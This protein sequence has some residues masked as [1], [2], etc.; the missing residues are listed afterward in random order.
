MGIMDFVI[1]GGL[2]AFG[3]IGIW[4]GGARLFFGF[5]MLLII[6]VGSAF[7]SAAVTPHIL[8]KDTDAGVE[9]TAPAQVIMTPLGNAFPSDGD[10]AIL[11]DTE[12]TLGEDEELYIGDSGYKL[13]DVLS[14]NIP[15]VGQFIASFVIKAAIPG[16]SLRESVTY[17]LTSYIYEIVIWVILVIILAIIR[18]ILRKKLCT[19]L[20]DKNH[21]ALSK[22]DR[23]LGFVL[24]AVIF[25]A[26]LWGAGAV[27]ARFDDGAN[28]ANG[29]DTF[30]LNGAI[31]GPIMQNNPLLK[32]INVTLPVVAEAAA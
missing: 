22:I 32:L 5:F 28:W 25:L 14:N 3:L 7:I 16:M 26:I 29:V 13:K 6:M 19:F 10:F 9:F 27:I 24:N 30:F 8:K 23:V 1:I 17:T 18:N 2:I 4:K 15:V 12:L 11:L 21:S 20:D 31:A